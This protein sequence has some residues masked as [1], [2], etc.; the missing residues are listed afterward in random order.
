MSLVLKNN[1]WQISDKL[2]QEIEKLLPERKK[3][4]YGGHNPRVPD[5][6]AMNAIFLVLRTGMQW[7]ALNATGV[8]TSSSAYRRFKEWSEAGVFE[9]LWQNG[10]CAYDKKKD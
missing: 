3:H 10:L 8:C 7:N 1:K 2:W 9:K 4:C 6:S 5:R